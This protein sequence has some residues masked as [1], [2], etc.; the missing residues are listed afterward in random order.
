M[1]IYVISRLRVNIILEFGLTG[2]SVDIPT[3]QY[4]EINKSLRQEIL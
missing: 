4:I 3:T 1:Y 2:P